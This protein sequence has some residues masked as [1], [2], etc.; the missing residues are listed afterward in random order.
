MGED[1]KCKTVSENGQKLVIYLM[2][3]NWRIHWSKKI[4]DKGIDFWLG[5]IGKWEFIYYAR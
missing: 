1:F 2:L 3:G 4:K 5:Q